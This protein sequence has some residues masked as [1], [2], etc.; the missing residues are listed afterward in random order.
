MCAGS[1]T[2]S[3]NGVNSCGVCIWKDI[4][5]NDLISLSGGDT[6]QKCYYQLDDTSRC[7]INPSLW[8]LFLS[9]LTS[10]LVSA[11]EL[12]AVIRGL[13]P[14]VT[15]DWSLIYFTNKT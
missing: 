13:V 11:D 7:L 12:P 14:I 9:S 5:E 10:C 4:T 8:D 6:W 3:G 1:I 15:G 2:Q